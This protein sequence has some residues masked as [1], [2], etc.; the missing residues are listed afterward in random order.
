MSL[1]KKKGHKISLPRDRNTH[2][3]SGDIKCLKTLCQP[4]RAPECTQR[5]LVF[6]RM[7]LGLELL[8]SFFF[9]FF[10]NKKLKSDLVTKPKHGMPWR[11]SCPSCVARGPGA[12]PSPAA[13]RWV[14][15]ARRG[16][17]VGWRSRRG[18]SNQGHQKELHNG[19]AG[20]QGPACQTP[21]ETGARQGCLCTVNHPVRWPS[22]ETRAPSPAIKSGLVARCGREVR[23]LGTG[24]MKACTNLSLL[25]PAW[26]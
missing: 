15:G 26:F 2:H 1:R 16:G 3:T 5:C 22:V 4:V 6:P 20:S 19:G 8:V 7:P 12:Q 17:G 10:K 25:I 14:P 11:D 9:F 24:A 21:Q 18:D 23:E 13:L